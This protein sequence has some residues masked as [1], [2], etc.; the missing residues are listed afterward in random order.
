MKAKE[1]WVS[2]EDRLPAYGQVVM[3]Y[4]KRYANQPPMFTIAM[5]TDRGFEIIDNHFRWFDFNEIME[6]SMCD[7]EDCEKITFWK[8]I[9]PPNPSESE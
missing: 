4:A 2:V 5:R 7:P 9:E 1:Q 3:V 8:P 6:D